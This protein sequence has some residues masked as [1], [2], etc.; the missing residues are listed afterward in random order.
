MAT[1]WMFAYVLNGDLLDVRRGLFQLLQG[2]PLRLGGCWCS[3][4]SDNWC[5]DRERGPSDQFRA[6]D[7]CT[8]RGFA[9]L[10][11]VS[12][13]EGFWLGETARARQVATCKVE[14]TLWGDTV[15]SEPFL[16]QEKAAGFEVAG[17]GSPGNR[18]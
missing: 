10:R 1:C 7:H 15:Q 4:A 11:F 5:V 16:F 6:P 14:R 3:G 18:F 2:L 8:E 17:R 12:I 9:W 13:E